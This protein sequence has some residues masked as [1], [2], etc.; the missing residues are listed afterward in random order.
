MVAGVEAAAL[1]LAAAVLIA[2]TGGEPW[3]G[4]LPILLYYPIATAC[5]GE[6]VA[7]RLFASARPTSGRYRPQHDRERTPDTATARQPLSSVAET[8]MLGPE[9]DRALPTL[10]PSDAN[11]QG[12]GPTH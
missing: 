1:L 2:V 8:G 10:F 6:T 5:L 7:L 11:P 3:A 4:G 9:H 12:R